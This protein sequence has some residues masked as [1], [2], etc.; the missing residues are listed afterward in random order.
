MADKPNE[1]RDDTPAKGRLHKATYATDKKK[2]GYL[3]RVAG[4]TANGFAGREVP[5]NTRDGG[6]HMER[7]TR[8]IWSGVDT[9][10][11]GNVALYAFESRPRDDKE[12]ETTF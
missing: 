7:L 9:E 2:G 12:T 5:V 10:T 8:L 1:T 3:I 4:P 11:G 6:E